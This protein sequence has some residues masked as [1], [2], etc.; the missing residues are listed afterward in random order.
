MAPK[1]TKHS[2]GRRALGSHSHS[3]VTKQ[4]LLILGMH[5][6][7]TSALT[8]VFNL[9]GADL[10]RNIL[11]AGNGN[12]TGHWESTDL[13]V[14]HD[15]MLA[16]AGT[17]WHDW[18]AVNPDWINS[19]AANAIKQRL[20]AV[21]CQDYADSTLF[22]VKDPRICRFV[23][24]WLNILNA[25]S[26]TP[27]PVLPIRSPLEVAASLR[28]R[29]G[30]A[31][32]KS[33]L[34]WLRHALDAEESTRTLPRA[35]VTY[36]ML[37]DDWRAVANLVTQRT[38][39]H[40][41]RMSNR[42][43]LEIDNFLTNKQRHHT[44]DNAQLQ[45][46]ADVVDWVK[47]AYSIMSDMS[48]GAETAEHHN[49]LDAIRLSFDT[50]ARAFGLLL[51]G[52]AEDAEARRTTLTNERDSARGALAENGHQLQ[53]LENQLAITHERVSE[54]EKNE[55]TRQQQLRDSQQQIDTIVSERNA[56]R[57]ALAESGYQLENATNALHVAQ[58]QSADYAARLQTLEEEL[59]VTR[60]RASELERSESVHQHEIEQLH[61]ELEA[62]RS[63]L[64][65]SQ[66]MVQRLSGEASEAQQQLRDTQRQINA[67]ASERDFAL[68]A[69]TQRDNELREAQSRITAVIH[70]RDI[71][72]RDASTAV[73]L[74][75]QQVAQLRDALQQAQMQAQRDAV[76][77]NENM[78]RLQQERDSFRDMIEI[79]R[80]KIEST[81][82]SR[83]DTETKRKPWLSLFRF[84]NRE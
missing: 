22:T 18:R 5:R 69:L 55:A 10:P 73:H 13:I 43:E 42:S 44:T 79:L 1:P 83:P 51:A 34:L 28:R 35:I 40:W 63:L 49:A 84:R 68:A 30:F 52:E 58:L 37:L 80:F 62:G 61:H 72:Q 65:D 70:D 6:S 4:A 32:T 23:P 45:A 64:R 66:A 15:E 81:Q 60:G 7:G 57:A 41:P 25:F 17:D 33:Y 3:I 11:G 67:V 16:A 20:L 12:E 38:G 2:I 76:A 48:R 26:T 19:T 74:L 9:L 53:T 21:L 54:L 82:S 29:D 14:I 27:I 24:L 56:A 75:H 71:F 50:A 39:L 59:V 47:H 77:Q 46:R 36:D 31:L 8:R 78:A